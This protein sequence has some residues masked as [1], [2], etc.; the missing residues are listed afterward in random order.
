MSNDTDVDVTCPLRFLARGG[1]CHIQHLAPM[2]FNG[3]S[4][5]SYAITAPPPRISLRDAPLL[6]GPVKHPLSQGDT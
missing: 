6:K 3:G 2:V 4:L 5:P 1:S